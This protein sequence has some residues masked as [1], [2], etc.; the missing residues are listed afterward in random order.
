MPDDSTPLPL[1]RLLRWSAIGA[2]I[3]IGLALYFRLGT[4]LPPA[5]ASGSSGDAADSTY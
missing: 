4:R 2:L 5:T 3:C 1:S